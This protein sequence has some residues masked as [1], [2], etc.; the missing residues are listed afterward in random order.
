MLALI[1]PLLLV[2]FIHW[3]SCD[4]V[5]WGWDVE[6]KA[7]E[8]VAIKTD[9]E[10]FIFI[11]L[12]W[13]CRAVIVPCAHTERISWHIARAAYFRTYF[14]TVTS[15][16]ALKLNN[17]EIKNELLPIIIHRTIS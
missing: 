9:S 6:T 16:L 17:T 1:S 8:D 13:E 10:N 14:F 3:V 15:T 11:H 4:E 12:S 5:C 2:C 7:V